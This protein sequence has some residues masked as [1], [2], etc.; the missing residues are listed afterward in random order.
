MKIKNIIVKVFLVT[1]F[2]IGLNTIVS[3]A[4]VHSNDPTATVNST[5]SITITSD[6][7]LEN[8]NISV[9]DLGGLTFSSVS[10]KG[11]SNGTAVGYITLTEPLTTL[12][13]Y[14][15]KTPSTPGTYKVVF[16]VNGTSNTSTV[17]VVAASNNNQ[18]SDKGQTSNT[19]NSN[20]GNSGNSSTATTPAA[21]SNVATL[22]NLGISPN[23]FSGFSPSKTSYSTEVPNDVETIEIYAKK[24]QSG[25][26]I[27]GTGKKTLKEGTNTFSIVVTAEDGKTQKTYTLN[28]T[29]K[30]QED[31]TSEE[32]KI[33]PEEAE[34]PT[35]QA[36]GLTELTISGI[37]LEPQFKTD[38]YEYTADL[39][40]D[41]NTLDIK[42]IATEEN[43][44]VEIT[45]NENLQDGE[46]IITITV[47]GDGEDKNVTYKITVSKEIAQEKEIDVS[48][49]KE[50][51]TY[52]IIATV[53]AIIIIILVVFI[54]KKVT[55]E[56][57]S[58]IP[59]QDI[60]ND[61]KNDK[62]INENDDIEETKQKKKNS[63]GKRFK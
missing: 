20:S 17:K 13:T 10:T 48:N 46:N 32:N 18:N 21:K 26:T 49:K 1:V 4:A 2:F 56:D 28:I 34:D 39:K 16:D 51:L 12:A 8:F 3:K 11:I 24:G 29:R 44:K 15:F 58:F 63:K 31:T 45:G 59:Y 52:I 42:A 30:A 55:N 5:V 19:N 14:T 25:Q 41:L 36:F 50:K 54:V 43:A 37:E 33:S 27:S 57:E 22:S 38:V 9:S 47:K 61:E 7:A 53:I 62:E 40:S 23:D 6:Q 60:N 35:A